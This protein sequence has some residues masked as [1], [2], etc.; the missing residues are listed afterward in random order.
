MAVLKNKK[1]F[2]QT[3]H[4]FK[5]CD[6]FET[7]LVEIKYKYI[8]R[9]M[10]VTPFT[11]PFSEGLKYRISQEICS[12]GSGSRFFKQFSYDTAAYSKTRFELFFFGNMQAIK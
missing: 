2:V 9:H 10:A 1:W 11:S 12:Q 8:D 5:M 6:T 7:Y 4:A 3:N